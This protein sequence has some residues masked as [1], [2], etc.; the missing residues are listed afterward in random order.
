MPDGKRLY[1]KSCIKTD[2]LNWSRNNR[3]KARINA[4]VWYKNNSQKAKIKQY[5]YRYG[6]TSEQYNQ[7]LD[8]QQSRCAICEEE[9]KKLVIDHN[10]TTMVVR[11]LLCHKCNLRL[12]HYESNPNFSKE[13][14]Y[15]EKWNNT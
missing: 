9:K 10:H 13:K 11:A 7:M 4:K 3:E 12:G 15:L 1:C 5:L 6:L 8:D 2:M 14:A